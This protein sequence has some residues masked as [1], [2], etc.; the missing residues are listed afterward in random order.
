MRGTILALSLTAFGLMWAGGSIS[1][2]QVTD[3]T[4][5]ERSCY[6]RKSVCV[7][8]CAEH[9]NPVE[10]EARCRDELLDCLS[11]CR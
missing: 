1:S 2:A 5:C 6:E 3:S 8:I 4:P 11:Q 9:A 10:C 7:D